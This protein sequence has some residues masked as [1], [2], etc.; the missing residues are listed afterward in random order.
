MK[1]IYNIPEVSTTLYA[2][3]HLHYKE[4]SEMTKFVYK[5]SLFQPPLQ[6]LSPPITS[7]NYIIQIIKPLYDMSEVNIIRFVIY[8]LY[9]KNKFH[10][11]TRSFV[12][13]TN[14]LHFL[15]SLNNLLMAPTCA[16]E[17]NLVTKKKKNIKNFHI[18]S[19]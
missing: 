9:N 2:I 13:V 11:L 5:S 14:N 3:Y 1:P 4:K 8:H 12:S 18:S 16:I 10:N 7:S 6:L 19:F 15:Y 17:S